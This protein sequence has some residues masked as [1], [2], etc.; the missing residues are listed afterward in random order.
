M[1]SSETRPWESPV[2]MSGLEW[3]TT[4]APP[5]QP[6]IHVLTDQLH[7]LKERF[8][9]TE[10]DDSVPVELEVFYREQSS[11]HAAAAAGVLS[12]ADG[13][14]G[15]YLLEQS[16]SPQTINQFIHAVGQYADQT[17]NDSKYTVSFVEADTQIRT[18]TQDSFLIYSTEGELIPERSLIPTQA[19]V[20]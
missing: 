16:M 8:W 15:E 12:I 14:T 9:K 2:R 11:E 18:Y 20:D 7:V 3:V 19:E 5:Q 1:E 6:A 10:E 13:F 17:D 4:G